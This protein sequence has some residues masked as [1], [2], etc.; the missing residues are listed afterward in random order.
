MYYPEMVITCC[1]LKSVAHEVAAVSFL[2]HYLSG[3][4]PYVRMTCVTHLGEFNHMSQ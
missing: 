2:S 4:L 3:S 1:S